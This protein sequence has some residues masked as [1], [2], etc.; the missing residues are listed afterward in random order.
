MGFLKAYPTDNSTTLRPNSS[1]LEGA[2]HWKKGVGKQS[3]SK[4]TSF[5]TQFD[6]VWQGKNRKAFG[7]KSEMDY[8]QLAFLVSCYLTV[9]NIVKQLF[10][11]VFFFFF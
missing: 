3:L 1:R 10:L 11:S 2:F 4:V 6:V 7:Q 5:I 9:M 8:Y